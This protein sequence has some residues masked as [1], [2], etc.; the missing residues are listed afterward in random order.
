[1]KWV[2]NRAHP[3]YEPKTRMQKLILT[4]EGLDSVPNR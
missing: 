3:R 2:E 4:L 1:M